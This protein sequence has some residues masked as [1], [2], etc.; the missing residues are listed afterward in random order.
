[1]PEIYELVESK[2]NQHKP[3]A[4]QTEISS[5]RW[6][7]DALT[8]LSSHEAT[9][10]EEL[11]KI[12][13][14][15]TPSVVAPT[16]VDTGEDAQ[17]SNAEAQSYRCNDC[18]KMLRTW[19]AVQ[20]HAEKTKVSDSA[21]FSEHQNFDEST[22]VVKP[23][24]EEEKK[25]RLEE[26]KQRVAEK[27]KNQAAES[28]LDAKKN[29]AIRRKRDQESEKMK[30]E[31]RKK[32][33]LRDIE[34]RKQ[35]KLDDARARAKVKAE[36]AATQQARREAAAKAKA[37]RE[38]QTIDNAGASVVAPPPPLNKGTA[39]HTEARLRFQIPGAPPVT[40]TFPADTSLFEVA[41][42]L[43]QETGLTIQAFTTTFPPR[44]T[45]KLEEPLD[46][47]LTLK[48]A[49]LTP[50]ASLIVS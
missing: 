15:G 27:R 21:E 43:A 11:E 28:A 25:A 9:E 10:I 26:L 40:K 23:L 22:E 32:E 6:V 5:L 14:P 13:A 49:N 20:F 4:K 34:R 48:E 33:Q 47:G 29:E 35:E 45:F 37:E 12:A 19:E 44:K 38:G 42:S 46:S 41:S 50:S 7:Q 2:E 36:I 31:L 30:E 18:G 8:W 24:T 3:W 17:K 16:E 1:M 39:N